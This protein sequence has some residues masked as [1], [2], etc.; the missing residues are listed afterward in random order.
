MEEF[1]MV[2]PPSHSIITID[3]EETNVGSES[4]NEINSSRNPNRI[5]E[6]SASFNNFVLQ[7]LNFNTKSDVWNY[8]KRLF[9]KNDSQTIAVKQAVGRVVCVPCFRNDKI[10]R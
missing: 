2:V 8:M 6:S 7:P 4:V 10:K 5:I 9:K 1:N 3:E